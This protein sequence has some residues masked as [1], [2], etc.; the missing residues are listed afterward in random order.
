MADSAR[1]VRRSIY[2]WDIL[3]IFRNWQLTEI[4]PDDM[5]AMCA[6]VRGCGAATIAVY[7]CAILHLVKE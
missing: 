3:S 1:A 6:Q 7:V 2:E 5:R 4:S